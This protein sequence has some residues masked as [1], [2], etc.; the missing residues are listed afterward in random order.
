MDKMA[1][2][3]ILISGVAHEINN[4]NQFVMANLALLS[5]A[6]ESAKPILESYY[7]ENGDFLLGDM[8]YSEMREQ[9]QEMFSEIL[10]GCQRIK[11]IV[12]ELR[13]LARQ[14]PAD[15]T[16]T[17]EINSVVESAVTLLTN[18]IGKSTDHFSVHYGRNLPKLKGSF[19]RLEQVVINLIQNACQA[20]RDPQESIAVT[21]FYDENEGA[22][23]L[24]VQDEGA[25]MPEDA[26]SHIADPFYTTR[27]DSGGTGLGV[28]IST[29]IVSEHAGILEFDS[30]PGKGTTAT[31]T[32]PLQILPV[33]KA[34]QSRGQPA[35]G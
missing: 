5:D 15:M 9:I 27:R 6:W 28:S 13:D 19:R 14:R 11:Y 31:V 35:W 18:M 12:H 16:E 4:P 10:G 8:N 34:E 29:S 26:L 33:G 17:V 25:G 3:G 1:S 30:E 23:I 2:L 24:K 20:L 22:I 21:T 32:L 7:R